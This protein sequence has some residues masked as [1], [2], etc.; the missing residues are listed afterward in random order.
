[1]VALVLVHS[2]LVGPFTWALVA[3]ELERRH[4]KAVV[5]SL[6]S[7]PDSTIPYWMQHAHTV[8]NSFQA[9]PPS[10][11]VILVA[12]SGAGML[13]PAIREASGRQIDGY[14]FVDAGLPQ[15]GKSRLDLFDKYAGEQL[16]RSAVRGLLPTWTD[17]DLV[18]VIPDPQVRARFVADLRP[19]PLAVYQEPLPVP[20]GWPDAPCAFVAFTNGEGYVYQDVLNH[21]EQQGWPC[22]KIEGMH[23]HMLVDPVAVTDALLS[24]TTQMG[25]ATMG[26]GAPYG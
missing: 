1:L 14:I 3:Q 7:A 23:F 17:E 24:V 16:R 5:P 20:A 12:H 22:V 2:P 15:D 19:L 26:D 8:A 4:M 11:Q 6:L 9:L 21:A 10:E 13:L 18:E 25:L